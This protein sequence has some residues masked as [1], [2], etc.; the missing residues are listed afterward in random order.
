LEEVAKYL[1]FMEWLGWGALIVRCLVVQHRYIESMR[2]RNPA[3]W[4]SYFPDGRWSRGKPEMLVH[5]WR[6][7]DGESVL[8]TNRRTFK[9]AIVFV[10]AWFGLVVVSAFAFAV[11]T[12]MATKDLN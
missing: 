6:D 5:V 10:L 1:F 3:L 4:A 8:E 2:I 11:W 7:I 12:M 9:R